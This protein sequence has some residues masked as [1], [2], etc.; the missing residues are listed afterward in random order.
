M[1]GQNSP[2][3]VQVSA[4][5][6]A[7]DPQA[8]R[9]L[10][11]DDLGNL[12]LATGQ[13]IAAANRAG[14]NSFVNFNVAAPAAGSTGVLR[15]LESAINAQ[16]IAIGL[17]PALHEDEPAAFMAVAMRAPS[18]AISFVAQDGSPQ[19]GLDARHVFIRHVDGSL[20]DSGVQFSLRGDEDFLGTAYTGQA[21]DIFV[22]LDGH[23]GVRHG[24]EPVL[25][26]LS[27]ADRRLDVYQIEPTFGVLAGDWDDPTRWNLGLIADGPMHNAKFNV[28]IF[29]TT[30]TL[31]SAK[32]T[33]LLKLESVHPYTIAGGGTLT[34]DAPAGQV[35]H[36]STTIGSHTVA[37]PV[38][39]AKN[40]NLRVDGDATLTLSGGI[41][42]AAVVKLDPGQ[43]DVKHVR[44]TSLTVGEGTLRIL[45]TGGGDGVSEVDGLSI[46][47]DARFDLT[48]NGLIVGS[49]PIAAV[50]AAIL[51]GR[52]GGDWS[53]DGLTSSAAAANSASAA[54]GYAVAGDLG[55]NRFMGQIVTDA[56]V[57]V[58]YTRLGDANLDGVVNIND[59]S[60]LAANFN[61]AG[62]WSDGDFDF[63][64]SVGITDFAQ[65]AANFNLAALA[66]RAVPEPS[67]VIV[68]AIALLGSARRRR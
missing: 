65:M 64:G 3:D 20:P 36:V 8:N 22:G 28:S 33:K 52:N 63:S 26:V 37:V 7:G 25:L 13:T 2:A 42:G 6:A 23:P 48:N 51:A 16:G 49:T 1:I 40:T 55:L 58:R 50:R 54:V 5:Q 61:T 67:M 62:D 9:D 27:A 38:V 45:P 14:D 44:T 12:L 35:A 30:V 66:E 29:P 39:A 60:R 57:L 68:A 4:G 31:N 43:A 11:F 17:V 19:T 34:L 18:D 32:S 56:D 46:A 15:K 59:F 24:G 21:K 10:A 41:S 47:P 53:G